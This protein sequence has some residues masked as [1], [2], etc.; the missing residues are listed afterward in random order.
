MGSQSATSG[1]AASCWGPP[2]TSHRPRTEARASL[3][4]SLKAFLEAGNVVFPSS[5]EDVLGFMDV[6]DSL[7]RLSGEL[8]WAKMLREVE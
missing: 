5:F 8:D 3:R 6:L 1:T 4:S 7:K 2:G